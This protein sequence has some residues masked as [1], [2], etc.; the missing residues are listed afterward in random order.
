MTKLDKPLRREVTIE[1][2][3]VAS[4]PVALAAL[5]QKHKLLEEHR[6]KVQVT[7]PRPTYN[8][9]ESLIRSV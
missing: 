4:Q 9:S 8:P 3:V 7:K 6:E 2:K 1:D 5:L